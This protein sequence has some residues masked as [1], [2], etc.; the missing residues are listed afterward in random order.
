MLIDRPRLDA[1][2]KKCLQGSIKSL[3]AFIHSR[4]GLT[5]AT[6]CPNN[7]L[8]I[9]IEKLRLSL[10]NSSLHLLEEIAKYALS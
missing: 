7:K 1:G 5:E 10:D 6:G 8:I 2:L 9:S 3:V 4:L